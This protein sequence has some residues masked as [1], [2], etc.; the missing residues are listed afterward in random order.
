MIHILEKME[1]DAWSLGSSDS[2][3]YCRISAVLSTFEVAVIDI[4]LN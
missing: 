2:L 1:K 3:C 4:E